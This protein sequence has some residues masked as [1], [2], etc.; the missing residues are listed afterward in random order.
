MR[1]IVTLS[2]IAAAFLL[3]LTPFAIDFVKDFGWQ[4]TLSK[5]KGR[6]L[7]TYFFKAVSPIELRVHA[8][9]HFSDHEFGSPKDLQEQFEKCYNNINLIFDNLS[10]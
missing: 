6:K 7:E 10:F 3:L 4:F 8:N 1:N 9:F 5:Q 2:A